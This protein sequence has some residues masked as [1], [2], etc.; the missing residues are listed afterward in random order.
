MSPSPTPPPPPAVRVRALDPGCPDEVALVARR[1]GETLDEVL[2]PERAAAVHTPA[3]IRERLLWHVERPADRRAEAFVAEGPDG[4]LLGHAL[5][6]VDSEEG[7]GEVGLLATI[8]VAP[9]A[10]RRGVAAALLERAT[11]WM[12]AAGQTL[13]VTYTDAENL[14][15]QGFLRE[16]GWEAGPVAPGWTRLARPLDVADARAGPGAGESPR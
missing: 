10:R 14:R 6:R 8:H 1:M 4:A 7:R 3:E 2:G 13:A 15:L 11:D 9:E 12:R 16:Q 5:V